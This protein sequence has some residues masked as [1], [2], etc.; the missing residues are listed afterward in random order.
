MADDLVSKLDRARMIDELINRLDKFGSKAE[1]RKAA[2]RAQALELVRQDP[3]YVAIANEVY[4]DEI[5]LRQ[6][7]IDGAR[8]A[9]SNG[10]AENMRA[11]SARLWIAE[12]YQR[13]FDHFVSQMRRDEKLTAVGWWTLTTNQREF[14]RAELKR[15]C[16]TNAESNDARFESQFISDD[17]IRQ[18]ERIEK[19][20]ENPSGPMYGRNLDYPN[21]ARPR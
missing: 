11:L 19:E 3:L 20:R 10:V 6:T 4:K 7:E 2:R 9:A 5:A 16:R 17:A 18:E 15:G 21:G 13:V 8:K 1:S 12:G 14:T